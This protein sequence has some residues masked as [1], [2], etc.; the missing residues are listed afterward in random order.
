MKVFLINTPTDELKE[1]YSLC[2]EILCDYFKKHNI[3]AFFLDKNEYGVHPS[4][5]KLKCFDYVQDDFILCWDMDLLPRKN[6]PN[7]LK[8]LNFS[9]INLVVDTIFYTKTK[10]PHTSYHK[11]N[12]GLIGLPLKYRH[13]TD[14]VFLESKTSILPSY[15]QYPINRELA[16]YN[17]KDVYELDKTWNC[18]FHLPTTPNSFYTS[19]KL[20]HYTGEFSNKDRVSLIKGHYHHYFS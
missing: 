9:K 18:I 16:K 8:E 14:K 3:S 20:I 13:I 5:L 6:T 17:F 4:W 10:P 12:C 2:S 11:Y 19:A 15:E 1:C 7:I